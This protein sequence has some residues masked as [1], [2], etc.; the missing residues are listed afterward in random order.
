MLKSEES[1]ARWAS[2]PSDLHLTS[3]PI[4]SPTF[5]KSQK[6]ADE[7]HVVFCVGR[8]CRIQTALQGVR[9]RRSASVMSHL[10]W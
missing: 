7:E 2:G 8:L 3:P 5:V 4:D 9:H 1:A 6:A 10:K